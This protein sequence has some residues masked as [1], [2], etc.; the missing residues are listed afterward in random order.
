MEQVK[1]MNIY[2]KLLKITSE[3][4]NVNKNLEVGVGKNKYKAVGEADVLKAVKELEEKYRIYSYPM[5]RRIVDREILETKKIYNGQTTEGNQIF[6][7]IETIYKF[8]NIDKPE[9]SIE[10]IT[11]GDGVDTQDKAPGKAMTYG[12]K[13]ALMKAYKIITGE[14]PDQNGSPDEVKIEKDKEKKLQE[15]NIIDINAK[16][17]FGKYKEKTWIEVYNENKSYFDWLIENAKSEEGKETY[18]QILREIESSFITMEELSEDEY[19]E[20]A[21]EYMAEDYG[22]R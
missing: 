2:E 20:L 10:I 3:M 13:Y 21:A 14:D 4:K 9:E 12:D 19:S 16:V 5:S 11:Y 15:E 18:K 22:D 8:I 17:G 6:M 7:R 1:E